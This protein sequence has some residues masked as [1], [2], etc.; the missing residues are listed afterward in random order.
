MPKPCYYQ[1]C[2]DPATTRE[3]V[4]PKAFFPEDQRSQLLTV[5]SCA[6]HNNAK[7]PDDIYALAHICMNAAPANRAR[8][9]F[10]KTLSTQLSFNEGALRKSLRAGAVDFADG[11]VAYPVDTRRLDRFFDSLSFGIVYKSA[12]AQLP[13]N[14]GSRNVYHN[15]IG[16]DGIDPEAKKGLVEFYSG[17]PDS[18]LNFGSVRTL[19]TTVYTASIFGMPEFRSSITVVHTFFGVF[20][21]TSML[22]RRIEWNPPVDTGSPLE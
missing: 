21:V 15:F 13:A 10:F 3:H 6:K 2:E 17:T 20:R 16:D 12:G 18:I 14:F 22:G 8:E 19:N 5:P 1:G 9:V 7:S 11:S 4:P